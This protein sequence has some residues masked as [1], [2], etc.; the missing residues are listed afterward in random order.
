MICHLETNS[1]LVDYEAGRRSRQH[2]QPTLQLRYT[3]FIIA[4]KNG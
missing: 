2:L 4:N 3:D 1:E